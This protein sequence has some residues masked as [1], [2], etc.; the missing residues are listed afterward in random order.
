MQG[1]RLLRRILPHPR[2]RPLIRFQR[3]GLP[4]APH[5]RPRKMLR[6]RPLRHVLPRL[7][8]LRSPTCTLIPTASSPVSIFSTVITLVVREPSQP[9]RDLPQ[10][11]P[12]LPP[13][14]SSNVSLGA[15]P[16]SA[17]SSFKWKTSL[18]PPS[19]SPARCGAAPKPSPSP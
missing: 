18:P 9:V 3:K 6:L 19:P 13:P 2:P 8:H 12:S 14:R 10:D 4:P 1:L 15:Y 5:R 11:T 17:A 16:P 7:R